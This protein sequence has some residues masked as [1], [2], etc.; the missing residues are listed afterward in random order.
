MADAQLSRHETHNVPAHAGH[1]KTLLGMVHDTTSPSQLSRASFVYPPIP[2]LR[3]QRTASL[4][5][6]TRPKCRY[7][8]A[9][10][11]APSSKSFAHRPTSHRDTQTAKRIQPLFRFHAT[12]SRR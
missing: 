5:V 10:I 6:D 7:H 2:F 1:D 9:H 11:R 4:A 3:V 12:T 8:Q